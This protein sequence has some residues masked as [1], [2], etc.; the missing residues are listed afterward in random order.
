MLVTLKVN[1]LIVE[2]QTLVRKEFVL[3]LPVFF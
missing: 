3:S 2:K 1:S